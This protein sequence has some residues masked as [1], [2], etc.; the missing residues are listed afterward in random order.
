MMSTVEVNSNETYDACLKIYDNG[1]VCSVFINAK[2]D[3][4]YSLLFRPQTNPITLCRRLLIYCWF[5]N[6]TLTLFVVYLFFFYLCLV[7]F[8]PFIFYF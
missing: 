5:T 8:I 1:L 4:N 6:K 7:V 2:V 3:V